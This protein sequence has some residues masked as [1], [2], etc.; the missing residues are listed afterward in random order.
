MAVTTAANLL[1]LEAVKQLTGV[2]PALTRGRV[3]VINLLDM[4]SSTQLVLR[5][6]WCPACWDHKPSGE[7]AR[8]T[9]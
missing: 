7:A 8:V 4:S 5:K 2:L 6:P 1:A 9:G 3:V